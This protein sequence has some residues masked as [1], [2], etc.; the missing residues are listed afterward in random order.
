MTPQFEDSRLEPI[1]AKVESGERLGS[2]VF[3]AEVVQH[4][5]SLRPCRS[6]GNCYDC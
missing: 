3:V 1:R 6:Y 4:R 5:E 2:V